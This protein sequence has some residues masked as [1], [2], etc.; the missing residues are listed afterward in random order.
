MRFG[1][2]RDAVYECDTR[3]PEVETRSRLTLLLNTLRGTMYAGKKVP[4]DTN[5]QRLVRCG[6]IVFLRNLC[7]AH[8]LDSP[9]KG[10]EYVEFRT[11]VFG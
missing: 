2:I 7:A 11:R 1:D 4:S 6:G 3:T 9:K 5:I 8:D 10:M